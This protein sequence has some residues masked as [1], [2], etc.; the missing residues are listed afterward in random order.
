MSTAADQTAVETAVSRVWLYGLLVFIVAVSA[1]LGY[2]ANIMDSPYYDVSYMRNSDPYNFFTWGFSIISGQAL[3][4]GIYYQSPLYPY[5][6][7]LIFKVS[8][9]AGLLAPRLVQL[10]MGS[11]TAVFAWALAGKIK[12]EIA[13]VAAGLVVA[14]YGPLIFYEAALLRDGP[15]AFFNTAFLLALVDLRERPRLARA[16]LCGAL[17]G[18][19]VLAKPNIMVMVPVVGWSLWEAG[20]AWA[21]AAGKSVRARSAMLAVLVAAGVAVSMSPL[22]ARNLAVGAPPFAVT[23]SGPLEFIAGNISS[24][25]PS[26]LE[27]SPEVIAMARQAKGSTARAIRLVFESYHGRLADLVFRQLDKTWIF[28]N[29]Y[30]VPNNLNYYAEKRYSGYMRLPWITWPV[31]LGLAAL[32][33]FSTAGQ[34]RKCLE[35]HAYVLLISAGT[36]AFFVAGRFRAPL[37]PVMGVFAGAG[38]AWLFELL[39]ERR[40]R[41][42]AAAAGAA[43]IIAVIVW[44]RPPDPLR[45]NDYHNLARYHM[46]RDEP[47]PARELAD[48]GV[49]RAQKPADERGDAESLYRLA[50]LTFL[51]GRP[52]QEVEAGL[53]RAIKA[54]PPAW[55]SRL[56]E[57]LKDEC[58]RRREND[59]MPGGFRFMGARAV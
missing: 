6:L 8:G 22:I 1:R 33:L 25:P 16:L 36:I 39:R 35:L 52:L 9:G 7:A 46:L 44:P 38:G 32:G 34:W 26:G 11:C 41:A 2:L 53:D 45:P 30:E 48:E 47:G 4:R 55:V 17:F 18:L 14:L 42:L 12:G 20:K 3:G 28:L 58:E 13:G 15:A 57:Q 27:I 50:R 29:G 51:A 56:V 24:A 40:L 54:N 49:A 59:P 37:A 31:L 5:F 23:R 21:E 19:C 10:L 43:V